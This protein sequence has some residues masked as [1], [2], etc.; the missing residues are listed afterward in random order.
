M[1]LLYFILHKIIFW[2]FFHFDSSLEEQCKLVVWFYAYEQVFAWLALRHC[3]YLNAYQ[4]Y[5]L[6]V[7]RSPEDSVRYVQHP[8]YCLLD[9]SQLIKVRTWS[10]EDD[11]F[12][13]TTT[14]STHFCSIFILYFFLNVTIYLFSSP[15]L[16]FFFFF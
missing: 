4:N 14:V 7:L 10:V 15:L 3:M 16:K 13:A 11:S 8:H 9:A 5:I 2:S 6:A 1:S 12:V